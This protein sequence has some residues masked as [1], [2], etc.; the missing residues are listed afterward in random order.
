MVRTTSREDMR[1]IWSC[2]LFKVATCMP[3]RAIADGCVA[4]YELVKA[5]VFC[6]SANVHTMDHLCGVHRSREKKK[7]SSFDLYQNKVTPLWR[8]QVRNDCTK[9]LCDRDLSCYAEIEL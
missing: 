1:R 9:F 3:S 7:S 5:G 6:V 4:E 2:V 8:Q